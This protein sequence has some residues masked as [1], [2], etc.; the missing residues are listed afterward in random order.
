MGRCGW[1]E[2]PVSDRLRNR[3]TWQSQVP[4]VS[5]PRGGPPRRAPITLTQMMRLSHSGS[6]GCGSGCGSS[7]VREPRRR[8][9]S[10]GR[11]SQPG[12]AS[13]TC[14]P[15]TGARPPG[16]APAPLTRAKPHA[17]DVA[18][19]PPPCPPRPSRA[20]A[21]EPAPPADRSPRAE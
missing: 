17:A 21:P 9:P 11:A 20:T 7:M 3:W 13:T 2:S 8:A 4:S 6:S 5:P 12:P 10:D 14:A 19:R 15:A 1:V 16:P 18:A